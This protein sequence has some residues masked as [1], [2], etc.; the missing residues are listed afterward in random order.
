MPRRYPPLMDEL[1]AELPARR[2]YRIA[3]ELA[4]TA[5]RGDMDAAGFPESLNAVGVQLD[6]AGV[7]LALMAATVCAG[8]IVDAADPVTALIAGT[9]AVAAAVRGRRLK[10]KGARVDTTAGEPVALTAG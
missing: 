4:V 1:F 5:G 3:V 7:P 8:V 2:R 10:V 9:D 6:V